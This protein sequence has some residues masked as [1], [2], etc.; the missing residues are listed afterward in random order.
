M[1]A[2]FVGLDSKDVCALRVE[3]RSEKQVF[4]YLA[5]MIRGGNLA[6]TNGPEQSNSLSQISACG[7]VKLLRLFANFSELPLNFCRIRRNTERLPSSACIER[8]Q[9]HRARARNLPARASE[10]AL[11]LKFA[12]LLRPCES[13]GERMTGFFDGPAVKCCGLALAAVLRLPQ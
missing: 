3:P 13:R 7:Q 9:P 1:H 11:R 4:P 12:K 2:R 6:A 8:A 10:T 5:C